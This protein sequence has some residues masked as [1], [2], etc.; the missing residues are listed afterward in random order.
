MSFMENL[1]CYKIGISSVSKKVKIDDCCCGIIEK[2]I[3]LWEGFHLT[4]K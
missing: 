2:S 1:S 3:A 4:R